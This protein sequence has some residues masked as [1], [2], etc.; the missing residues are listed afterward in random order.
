MTTKKNN[1]DE[2]GK[3]ECT[4][5][6]AHLRCNPA[7]RTLRMDDY[8]RRKKKKSP[9]I[10]HPATMSNG[11]RSIEWFTRNVGPKWN[12]IHLA[13]ECGPRPQ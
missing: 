10:P 3:C 1:V 11:R 4:D 9:S 13:R 7:E 6:V 5:G 2:E 8:R 12:E